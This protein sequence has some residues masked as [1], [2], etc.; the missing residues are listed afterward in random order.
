MEYIKR[1]VRLELY[2]MVKENA[3]LFLL[4]LC[5]FQNSGKFHKVLV[6]LRLLWYHMAEHP[7]FSPHN[8]LWRAKGYHDEKEV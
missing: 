5:F 2:A 1:M 8:F 6:F 7:P 4:N 3:S